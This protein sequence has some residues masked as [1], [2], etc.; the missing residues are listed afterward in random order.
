[1][2][3]QFDGQLAAKQGQHLLPGQPG[4]AHLGRDA[5]EEGA[6]LCAADVE[7][8]GE[9][10]VVPAEALARKIVNKRRVDRTDQ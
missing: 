6:D 7:R 8:G 10:R 1:M 9:V 4:V 3:G 2:T 5:K